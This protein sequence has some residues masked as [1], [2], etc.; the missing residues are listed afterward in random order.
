VDCKLVGREVSTV[1]GPERVCVE[2]S[3]D[4]CS[5]ER[6]HKPIYTSD[7]RVSVLLEKNK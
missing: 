1:C 5:Q 6:Q 3:E 2:A 4:V 7:E